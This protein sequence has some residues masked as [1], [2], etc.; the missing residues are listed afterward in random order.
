MSVYD[1]IDSALRLSRR[2]PERGRW[3]APLDLPDD[4]GIRWE[5]Q[6]R[7]LSHYNVWA[8]AE[9]LRSLVTDVLPV[10]AM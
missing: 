5:Q 7:D 10:D 6:G 2:S 4:G 9:L 3:I 8:C 1:S